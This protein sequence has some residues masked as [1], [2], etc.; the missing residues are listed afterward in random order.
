MITVNNTKTY[1]E[2]ARGKKA[3]AKPESRYDQY[4][5]AALNYHLDEHGSGAQS[6]LA[7]GIKMRQSYVSMLASGE[8]RGAENTRRKIAAYYGRPY[9]LFMKI[10]KLI[11]ENKNIILSELDYKNKI[12]TISNKGYRAGEEPSAE[13]VTIPVYSSRNLK[14]IKGLPMGKVVDHISQLPHSKNGKNSFGVRV[15]EENMLPY[16]MPGMIVVIDPD[17]PL[18]NGKLCFCGEENRVF[19]YYRYGDLTVLKSDN[20]SARYPDVEFP[21]GITPPLY[22]VVESVRKE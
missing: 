5:R 6:E 19:R 21:D 4:F 17:A 13:P 10:G 20:T 14:I 2:G 18:E 22:R 8:K 3:V 7:R 12:D 11:T 16:I 9:E 1:R 15:G